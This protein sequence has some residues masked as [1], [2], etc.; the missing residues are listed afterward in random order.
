MSHLRQSRYMVV[1]VDDVAMMPPFT[2]DITQDSFLEHGG[3]KLPG[4][5]NT[6]KEP[7]G[8][9][10]LRAMPGPAQVP[11]RN[12]VVDEQVFWLPDRESLVRQANFRPYGAPTGVEG[13]NNRGELP[14]GAPLTLPRAGYPIATAPGG[15]Q[16]P[17]PNPLR[18]DRP[19]FYPPERPQ[20]GRVPVGFRAPINRPQPA[21]PPP[22]GIAAL[23]ALKRIVGAPGVEGLMGGPWGA[24]GSFVPAMR[25]PPFWRD[26]ANY[27]MKSPRGQ[28]AAR[29]AGE[30]GTHLYPH[31]YQTPEMVDQLGRVNNSYINKMPDPNVPVDIRSFSPRYQNTLSGGGATG[32][33][34]LFTRPQGVQWANQNSLLQYLAD[35]FGTG[36]N[37]IIFNKK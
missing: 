5:P 29:E 7:E 13:F 14:T 27:F 18:D 11:M 36:A 24:V 6:L 22:S 33:A 9:Y 8:R 23:D 35:H 19:S 37:D 34:P 17:M 12:P 20:F 32:P 10:T 15:S 3:R 1:G 16:V 2:A 30:G 31:H 21:T 25:N 4:D 26:A 28:E